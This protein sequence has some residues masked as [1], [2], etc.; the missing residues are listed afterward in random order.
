MFLFC[1]L[2][3]LKD[4]LNGLPNAGARRSC[5]FGKY[6]FRCGTSLTQL[7]NKLLNIAGKDG[8]RST[9]VNLIALRNGDLGWDGI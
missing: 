9:M 2:I 1:S 3:K 5:T 4:D 7:R 6:R 8:K